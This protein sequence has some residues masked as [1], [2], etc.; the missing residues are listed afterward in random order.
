MFSLNGKK[1]IITGA[2]GKGLGSGMAKALLT[3]G[4]SL[5]VIDVSPALPESVEALSELGTV[6]GV[7]ADISTHD[8][9][10]KAFA[11][12]GFDLA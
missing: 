10:K 11:E 5:A 12:R 1:A 7:H 4:A 3:A 8:G 2:A 6:Y 9:R